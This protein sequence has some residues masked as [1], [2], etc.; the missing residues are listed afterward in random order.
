MKM[1]KACDDELTKMKASCERDVSLM[2][3][4]LGEGQALADQDKETMRE[5]CEEALQAMKHACDEE[6][7]MAVDQAAVAVKDI[8]AELGRATAQFAANMSDMEKR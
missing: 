6:V 4:T 8:K 5:T 2:R 1:K 7:V 3:T